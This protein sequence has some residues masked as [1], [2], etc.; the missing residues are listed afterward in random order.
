MQRLVTKTTIAR[1]NHLTLHFG[2]PIPD[3]WMGELTALE[4][5]LYGSVISSSPAAISHDASNV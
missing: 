1:G 2:V 5:P 4:T 3:F